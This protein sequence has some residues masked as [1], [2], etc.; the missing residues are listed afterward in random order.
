MSDWERRPLRQSQMVYGALDAFCLLEL[1]KVLEQ[2]ANE[3]SLYVCAETYK[4]VGS[5]KKG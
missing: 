4:K 3:L 2:L 5:S 1:W